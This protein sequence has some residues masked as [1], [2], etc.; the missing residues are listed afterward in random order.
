MVFPE[1]V[2]SVAIEPKT[3][4]DQDKLGKALGSLSDEDP[5]FQVHTDDETGQTIISGMGELHL[6]V[7]VD[8]MMREFGVDAHVGKP[9][10][11]Y[12]ETITVP[13]EKVEL[14][15]VRQTGGRGQYAH[16][17]I[18]LEPTGPGGG[19][20]F[21]NEIH[22]GVIP[23]EYIPAV[24]AGMQEAMEGG[25]VAGYPL[26]DVRARL[27]Y[28][29]YH[30]VDS[31][32]MAFKIA[33]SMALKDAVKKAKPVLLEPMMAVEVVTADE[34]M[35]DVIGDLNSRRGQ[36][37]GMSQRGNA[38]VISAKVPLA[39]MFGY[40]GDL[41]SRTQGR[42]T[43]TMQFDSYQRVPESIAT[44]IVARVRGE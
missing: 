16:V 33:G 24:D 6:E 26:V 20:E 35:G 30:E 11:A 32:E 29:S 19:Y 34:Y 38:Q 15:Y 37:E 13:V 2:I 17:V 28:G 27:T 31:S 39:E 44:E 4:N 10:V 1:P 43:Y 42:A 8:R 12:R 21:V 14:R 41:R 7:L 22:G 18:A 25:V 23:R 36:V 9:Q 5:T 3:K 40:V